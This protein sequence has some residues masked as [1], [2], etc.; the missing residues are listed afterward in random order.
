[1]FDL[2]LVQNNFFYQIGG[3]SIYFFRIK[4]ASTIKLEKYII[5]KLYSDNILLYCFHTDITKT[6]RSLYC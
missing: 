6:D 5:S 2:N 4:L 1:M 3:S